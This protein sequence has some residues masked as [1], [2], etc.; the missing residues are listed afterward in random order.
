MDRRRFFNDKSLTESLSN[1]T[2]AKAK[3]SLEEVF[4]ELNRLYEADEN[5]A[6]A[7]VGG[8]EKN[9]E[10]KKPEQ[11]T[12]SD[13]NKEAATVLNKLK[14]SDYEQFVKILQIAER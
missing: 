5:T 2:T 6:T 12:S 7:E 1:N 9:V 3:Y 10:T 11:T 13:S 14:N 8:E 4:S